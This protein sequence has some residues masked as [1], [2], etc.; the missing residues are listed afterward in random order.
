MI[1]SSIR[2]ITFFTIVSVV[3]LQS[4]K[5][6]EPG[7]ADADFAATTSSTTE[8]AGS[9]ISVTIN[10]SKPLEQS[11]T[12]SITFTTSGTYGT[13][14]TTSPD[15]TSGTIEVDA[16]K[17][18][19]F[20]SFSVTPIDNSNIGSG[21]TI[22]FTLSSA[23]GGLAVGNSTTHTLTITDD[24][25]PSA[26]DFEMA[27]GSVDEDGSAITVNISI[28]PGATEAGSFD[29]DITSSDAS[30]TT[31]YT[32][33]IDGSSGSF[34]IDVG[35]GETSK[36]FDITPIDNGT[37][38][39]DKTV[40]FSLSGF[41]GGVSAGSTNQIYTLTIVND[42]PM[43]VALPYNEGFNDCGTGLPTDWEFISVASDENWGCTSDTRG[44]TEASGDYAVEVNGFGGD[45][46]SDDWAISPPIDLGSNATKMNF[47]SLKRFDDAGHEG[48]K[49]KI[50][51]DYTGDP[52]IATWA[53]LTVSL[54]ANNGDFNYT[55]TGDID[56]SAYQ[57]V[58]HIAFHYT[59]TGT[60]GGS[61]EQWRIDELNVV[62]GSPAAMTITEALS[63]F[64]S[65][66]NGNNSAS[67]SYTVAGANLSEDVTV[68]AST[69]YEVSLN[70]VDFTSSVVLSSANLNAG[71]VTVYVRFSPTSGFDSTIPG[72][73]THES[74]ELITE[75][76]DVTGTETGNAGG[77][78]VVQI[79]EFHY[80]NASTDVGEFIEIVSDTD[81]PTNELANYRIIL[82]NGSDGNYYTDADLNASSETLDNFVK[83]TDQGNFYY[84]WEP[85]SIQNGP[86]AF[87]LVGP[88]G[89]IQFLSYEGTFMGNEGAAQGVMST[90]I[91]V[92][93]PSTALAGSSLQ[94]KGDGTWEFTDGTNTKGAKNVNE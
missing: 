50:A 69:H 23:S 77:G 76:V 58:H 88:S 22:T 1:R 91:G 64:G 68:T 9:A 81:I 7:K 80:D 21:V 13:D 48:L 60:G 20:K 52:S 89:L 87:A 3:M 8:D 35:Q 54:D 51:N 15:G 45:V 71:P 19:L 44:I 94:R 37:A 33:S 10:F 74:P 2:L 57:G 27:A 59:S 61:T 31:D 62:E 6:E 93:E 24:E 75:V 32:T 39:P 49:V 11:G 46:A 84:V 82:Y 47:Y 38:D 67:Q 17:G 34:T 72:T 18:E 70:D 16:S 36:S 85:S 30:Y 63:D 5:D 66:D 29:V 56:L 28:I 40:M 53:E 55:Y 92:S 78:P 41:T 86:D 25:G 26:V 65:V 79:N 4:C 12:M 83:T 43:P 73:L 90:D 42:E 14:F